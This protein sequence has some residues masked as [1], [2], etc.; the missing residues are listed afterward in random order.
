MNYFEAAFGLCDCLATGLLPCYQLHLL[1][2]D[3][4]GEWVIWIS[5]SL[6]VLRSSLPDGQGERLLL[7]H[8]IVP[9]F[10]FGQK[11]HRNYRIMAKSESIKQ[12][13]CHH[14]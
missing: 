4:T 9:A 11:R 6:L 2:V 1:Y 13:Q 3:L 14:I 8:S 7:T 10:R 12:R 5:Q